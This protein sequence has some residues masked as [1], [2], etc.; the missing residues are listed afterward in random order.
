MT[1]KHIALA[2]LM[3]SACAEIAPPPVVT[4]DVGTCGATELQSLVGRDAAVLDTMRFGQPV[5]MIRPDTMVTMDY[6]AER[7]NI[8]VN[9]AE[10]IDA[11]TCG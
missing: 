7:L 1:Y 3:L 11:V 6:S 9:A 10:K 5:R 2:L 8:R 4:P